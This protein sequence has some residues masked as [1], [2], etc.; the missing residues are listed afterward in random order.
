MI[1]SYLTTDCKVPPICEKEVLRYAGD[2]NPNQETLQLLHECIQECNNLFST[3]IAYRIFPIVRQ[4][5]ELNIASLKITSKSLKR[6]LS[7]CDRVILFATTAGLEID[8]LIVK[9]AKLS[10]ARSL[11]FHSIGSERVEA[12]CDAFCHFLEAE[13]NFKVTARFS[14]GYG[15]LPLELQKE[16]LVLLNANSTVGIGLNDSMVLSPTKSVTAFVGILP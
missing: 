5:D 4:L 13:E 16:I 11:M 2:P 8:R 3:K 12:L 10:P 14:P 15:D 7:K 9:Y 1:T 6:N